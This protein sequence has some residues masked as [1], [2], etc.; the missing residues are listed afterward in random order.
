MLKLVFILTLT[1]TLAAFAQEDYQETDY[2]SG[3]SDQE[4]DRGVAGEGMEPAVEMAPIPEES[5]GAGYDYSAE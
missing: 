5:D 1:F 2:G 4:I 3:T